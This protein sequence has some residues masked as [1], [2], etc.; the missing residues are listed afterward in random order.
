VKKA[1]FLAVTLL[2]VCLFACGVFAQS[3]PVI[4]ETP[5]LK[6]VVD[7]KQLDL[8]NIPINCNGRVLLGL[9]EVLVALG[10]KNDDEHI[11][12][13]PVNRS[14]KIIHD[15]IEIN[16]A[17]GNKKATVNGVEI[18]VDQSLLFTRTEPT[19]PPDLWLKAFQ[20]W[21]FGTNP[22]TTLLL[23]VKTCC[24]KLLIL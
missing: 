11:I 13:N 17:I 4:V 8:T 15:G 14:V 19:Y 12:W 3:N 10:V 20:G 21:F 6:V 1:I 9:R 16:L 5:T 24:M 2:C 18:E 7:G 23:P 22:L